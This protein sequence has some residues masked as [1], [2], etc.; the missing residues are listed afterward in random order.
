MK[1]FLDTEFVEGFHKPLFGKKRHY[2]ELI[3]IGIRAEDGRKYY[4][5]SNE[6]DVEKVW[7]AG[8]EK[9]DPGQPRQRGTKEYWLR[10]HVLYGIWK[11]FYSQES[12]YTKYHFPGYI[13]FSL[14]GLKNYIRWK[15]KSNAQIKSEIVEFICPM[16]TASDYAGVGSL[17]EGLANY[18]RH[19]PPE[20]YGYFADYDWVLF[21]SPFGRMVDLPKGF[22]YYCRDLKQMMTDNG[23]DNEWK[24]IH[25]PEGIDEHH[26]GK[27]ADWNFNLYQE[28]QKRGGMPV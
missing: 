2:I 13:D 18:L 9:F 22:P 17:D 1:Y 23:L 6:F 11:D 3:S 7:N 20:F 28:I 5:V 15:G 24:G 26:A 12:A 19:N 14:K 25:C 27:D 8:E 21:C 4:A 10:N 16:A